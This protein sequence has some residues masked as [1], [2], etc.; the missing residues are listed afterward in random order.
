[1]SKGAD[2]K[3]TNNTDD[4]STTVLAADRDGVAD[5]D[6]N[7]ADSSKGD[8]VDDEGCSNSQKAVMSDYD[9]NFLNISA[10]PYDGTIFITGDLITPQD[11][12][13]F[14]SISYIGTGLR[15]MFDRRNGGSWITIEPHIFPATFLDGPNIEIQINSEFTLE[16]AQIEAEKYAFLVGQLAFSLR[17]DVETMWIHKGVE[18]YGG[19]NNNILIHTGMTASYEQ[20]ETGDITEETLIHELAHTSIDAY[21]YNHS[22]W[23]DAVEDDEGRFISTYALDYPIRE[24][25]AE[26]FPLYIAVKYFPER[27]DQAVIDNTLST[28]LNRILYFDQQDYNMTLYQ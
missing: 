23:L 21:C 17:K 11:T 4:G 25:I 2:C 26:L 5:T 6:D 8:A 27:L 7:C 20:H 19:G 12:S 15:T 9:F 10:P 14:D 28:S 13:V 24:D 1:M 3:I 16:E 18:G 22:D